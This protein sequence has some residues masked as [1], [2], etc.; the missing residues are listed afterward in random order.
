MR[1]AKLARQD[2]DLGRRENI[3][4]DA[5]SD[6]TVAILAVGSADE[7]RA[8]GNTLN[9]DGRFALVTLDEVS[10]ELLTRLCPTVVLSPVLALRF[11][12]IDLAQRLYALGFTGRYR[13]VSDELPDPEMVERE[14]KQLCPGLDFAILIGS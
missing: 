10:E 11:D 4:Y 1:E 12:C 14:I 8:M 9:D 5:S 6:S 7:W 2:M 3:G 13:A